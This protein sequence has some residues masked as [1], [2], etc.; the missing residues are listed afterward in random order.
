MVKISG[1][2]EYLKMSLL[3][4]FRNVATSWALRLFRGRE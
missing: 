2:L 4:H 3:G 1:Y